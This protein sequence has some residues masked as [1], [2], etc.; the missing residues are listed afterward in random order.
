MSFI[1]T[2]DCTSITNTHIA[3]SKLNES[4]RTT[5][6]Y[7]ESYKLKKSKHDKRGAKLQKHNSV[8]TGTEK[9]TSTAH[10]LLRFALNLCYMMY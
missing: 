5:D 1:Y 7:E 10:V 9:Q 4:K 6:V 2:N 8:C 3:R